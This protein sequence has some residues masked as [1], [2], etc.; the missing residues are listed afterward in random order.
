MH[1]RPNTNKNPF[2]HML[3]CAMLLLAS[4]AEPRPAVNRVQPNVIDKAT[5]NDGKAWYYQTTVVDA[6]FSAFTF[7]GFQ[8]ELEK[9]KWEIQENVLIARRAF[10]DIAGAEGA[11][12]DGSSKEANAPVAS[13]AILSHFDIRREYNPLTGEEL[14]VI[15]E[16]TSDRPWHQR[17]YMRVDWSKN[18]VT[19][20]DFLANSDLFEDDNSSSYSTEPVGYYV[21]DPNDVNAPKFETKVGSDSKEVVYVDITNKVF[22]KPK[23]KVL[24]EYGHVPLCFLFYNEVRDCAASEVTY[25][26]SFLKVD[27]SRD[28]EPMEYSGKHM[29][30]AGYFVTERLGFNREYG[31]VDSEKV[32]FVNRHNLWVASHKKDNGQNVACVSDENCGGGG[33]RC[34][35]NLAR[36]TREVC[37]DNS[38]VCEGQP[39]GKLV[40]ACTIP[41]RERQVRKV[42]Y[43]VS[44]NFP[45]ELYPDAQH[46]ADEWNSAFEDVIDSVRV[47][48]CIDDGGDRASC[49]EENRQLSKQDSKDAFVLCHGPVK[50]GDDPSCGRVGT[51]VRPGDLR[52]HLIGY[53]NE[54]ALEAPLGYG[55]SSADPQTGEIIMANAF[56]YGAGIESTAVMGRDMVALLNGDVSEEAF[57]DGELVR[58]WVERQ[59]A[60]SASREA[61]TH[62]VHVD[63]FDAKAANE[64]MDFSWAQPS[65]SSVSSRGPAN[66]RSRFEQL[67][68]AEKRMFETGALGRGGRAKADAAIKALR[69]TEIEHTLARSFAPILGVDMAHA[70]DAEV[71][72]VS[73]FAGMRSGQLDRLEQARNKVRSKHCILNADFADEGLIGLAKEIKRLANAGATINWYGREY[74]LS[75]GNGKIDYQKVAEMLRHPIFDAVTAHEVGHTIGLRHNFTGSADFVNYSPEYWNIRG[76]NDK[77]YAYYSGQTDMAR[78]Q[79]HNDLRIREHAYS[80]VMDYGN[81]F[82]VT[83]ANGIGHYDRMAL[84]LGYGELYEVYENADVET[85]AVYDNWKSFEFVPDFVGWNGATPLKTIPYTD[86]LRRFHGATNTVERN[87]TR[88]DV[89]FSRVDWTWGRKR[90]REGSKTY[91]IVPYLFASDENADL[92]FNNLRYDA[93]ADA[94]ESVTSIIDSYWNGY[95][96]SHFRR[97]RIDFNPVNVFKRTKARYFEKLQGNY[98]SYTLIRGNLTK[99]WADILPSDFWES[100]QGAGIST[101]AVKAVTELFVHVISSPNSGDYVMDTLPAGGQ[102]L[103]PKDQLDQ[104][105]TAM[106]VDFL[107][108]R[109]LDTTWEFDRAGYYWFQQISRSGFLYDKWLALDTLVD[110]EANFVGRDTSTDVRQYQINFGKVFPEVMNALFASILSENY[111]AFAPKLN[112]NQV[113]YPTVNNILNN[114]Q[115]G[116]VIFPNATFTIQILAAVNGMTEIS[117]SYD[118]T[119]LNRSRLWIDGADE[120]FDPGT[121][122][123]VSWRDPDTGMTYRALSFV[124]GGREKGVAA[125]MIQHI[126][127]INGNVI[128]RR[129]Y[130]DLLDI[131][132]KLTVTLNSGAGPTNPVDRPGEE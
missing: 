89:P 128:E 119:F 74:Q 100:E 103:R 92:S 49:E 45:E 12:I 40:G 9:V 63:G 85:V 59:E 1:P 25:R 35:L 75:D 73:P 113:V 27:E 102:F 51:S 77:P 17:Q 3:L 26:N 79:M 22:V 34:D 37:K 109:F 54:P 57:A 61:D 53:V 116:T 56:V 101:A 44:D 69:G 76:V 65:S 129:S 130:R 70:T 108:G 29:E 78:K 2:V 88:I 96:F 122:P 83:D 39:K 105:I 71:A 38:G 125:Q 68:A 7:P 123:T 82:V 97:G 48:E 30:T 16:N 14:N 120:S 117:Q 28:Y 87:E 50:E 127:A 132:R 41:F 32:R 46:F 111:T 112:G 98:Q 104:G 91:A 121:A 8:G 62:A 126:Q 5:F 21:Q 47:N 33:S 6:P 10:E 13:Y 24:D 107:D 95:I 115:T 67:A 64:V 66:E 20:M 93:G 110:P 106:T 52:Y 11:G 118:Q 90:Y 42:A 131:V 55:P 43:H 15:G 124:E 114:D 60:P 58:A 18:L 72:T 84:K 94:Y 23:T 80:T 99:A 31:I 81:N 36:V 4:C 86:V 19:S